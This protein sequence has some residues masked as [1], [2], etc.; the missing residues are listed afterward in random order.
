MWGK[1]KQTNTSW[2]EM[3]TVETRKINVIVYGIFVAGCKWC[4][5][6][7]LTIRE[8][9]FVYAVRTQL[10]RP[11]GNGVEIKTGESETVICKPEISLCT[12]QL[13]PQRDDA[14]HEKIAVRRVDFAD[15]NG[16]VETALK[17]T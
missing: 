2:I 17:S 6:Y 1:T 15:G 11:N 16:Y 7:L 9:G 4:L 10:G 12:I 13:I 3:I 5:V 8:Q 14:H